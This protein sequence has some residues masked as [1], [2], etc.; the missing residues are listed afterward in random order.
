MN[1]LKP[2]IFALMIA[3]PGPSLAANKNAAKKDSAPL[4]NDSPFYDFTL[5]SLKGNI[6]FAKY[7]GQVVLIANIA[8]GCGYTPQLLGL[9]KLHEKYAGKGFVV[10]GFPSNDF[11]QEKLSDKEV[12]NFCKL[13]YGVQFDVF[14]K[15]HVSGKTAHPLFKYLTQTSPAGN[16]Q[17][18]KWNFEKFLVDRKGKVHARFGS[19]TEPGSKEIEQAISSVLAL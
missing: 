6:S 14:Q 15:I 17:S 16:N 12:V 11:N 7:K 9:Q 10:L 8:S 5:K 2:F 19:G 18:V 1:L 3:S 13:N 4:K